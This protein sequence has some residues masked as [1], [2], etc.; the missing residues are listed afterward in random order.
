[1]DDEVPPNH[2]SIRNLKPNNVNLN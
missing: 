1:V 2:R